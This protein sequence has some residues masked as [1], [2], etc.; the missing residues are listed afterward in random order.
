M[1]T[2]LSLS[3][4]PETAP[5]PIIGISREME[6]VRDRI[7]RF[8]RSPLPVLLVGPTGSGKEL[9]ARHIH[10][11]SGRPGKLIDVNCGA[12]PREMVESLLFG[13][14]KGAF[15]GA[16]ESTTGLV[17]RAHQ[18]TLFLDELSSLSPEGQAKLLRVVET[19]EV[20][21]LGASEKSRVDFRLVTAVQDDV[22]ERVRSGHFR[23]DLLHR[24]AGIRIQLPALAARPE[25]VVPLAKCFAELH[26]R[27]LE[28]ESHD[29]LRT[30][31]WPGNVRELRA[32]IDR[33]V[34]FAGE[35]GVSGRAVVEALAEGRCARTS[36]VA[37]AL[38]RRSGDIEVHELL[39]LCADHNWER[40]R[41]AVA[42][43]ISIAT[44][45][46]RLSAAGVSLKRFSDSQD[47]HRPLRKPENSHAQD[48][49]SKSSS[50][51][52]ATI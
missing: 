25:D 40:R 19:G 16:V 49:V 9:A 50:S 18:G 10:F 39:R 38:G 1:S 2:V 15:T 36:L 21:P 48:P 24:V 42:L 3:R 4:S 14:R 5:P 44:L 26:G 37:P 23:E 43:G 11:L 47:S 28:T 30:H 41:I 31:P 8:A 12:L 20:L 33:A 46:R 29:L 6:L 32:V 51:G 27:H 35:G 7:A 22:D 13:H 52:V 34:V 45:Y 17:T